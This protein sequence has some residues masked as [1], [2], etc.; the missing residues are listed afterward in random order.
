M[1]GS[2]NLSLRLQ[3]VGKMVPEGARL[4]DVGTDHAYLP[5]A[6]LQEGRIPFAI[7]ADLRQGPLASAKST[8]QRAGLGG[9]VAFRLCD[10]LSGIQPH[11]V[12]AVSI[13]GMGGGTIADILSAAPW[14]REKE[15]PLILQPMSSIPDL[16]IWLMHHGYCIVKEDLCREGDTLYTALLVQTGTMEQLTQTELW[17]GKNVNHSLR[18]LWL[19]RW[20]EKIQRALKGMEQ[21]QGEE[22]RAKQQTMEEV[23][24]GLCTMKQEWELWQQ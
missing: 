22:V 11:E 8:V 24:Y 9:K 2:Y 3:M 19:D 4:A 6:L 16:R 13:A 14:T 12:D 5:A 1:V 15:I 7:A 17:V 18:G 20:I 21:A 10:G 23:Y